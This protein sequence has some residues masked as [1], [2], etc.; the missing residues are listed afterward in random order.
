[1][2]NQNEYET[3]FF[4]NLTNNKLLSSISNRERDI[5]RLLLLN[6]TSNEISE[7]LHISKH[8]VD[9][10][11]R[12]IL[13]KFHLNSTSELKNYFKNNLKPL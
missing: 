8:T 12:N 7:K 3:L 1:M 2:N 5:V 10:H 6:K 4:N 13:K 11:R 9:T